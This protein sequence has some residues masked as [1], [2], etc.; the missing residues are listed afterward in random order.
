MKALT[1][2]FIMSLIITLS[3]LIIVFADVDTTPAGAKDIT[4]LG[5]AN[6]GSD[7]TKKLNSLPSGTYYF[8]AGRYG[9]NG[10][11]TA[12][13]MWVGFKPK[14]NS[15][16]IFAEDA[17]IKV[18]T[19]GYPSYAGILLFNVTNVN[20]INPTVEGD[21]LTH[22]F[23][24]DSTHEWGHGIL[25]VGGTGIVNIE[26]P[27]IYDVTGD[28]IDIISESSDV[29]ITDILIERAR[30]Q[31]ISIESAGTVVINGGTIRDISGAAPASGIDIEP[32]EVDQHLDNITISNIT[33][34]NTHQG[35]LFSNLHMASNYNVT[36]NNCT[37]DG[38]A[39]FNIKKTTSGVVNINN[40]II[41]GS[42]L[43][44]VWSN[45]YANINISNPVFNFSKFSGNALSEGIIQ[46]I[47]A[48]RDNGDVLGGL[49]VTNAQ[50]LN[51]QSDNESTALFYFFNTSKTT[52][53]NISIE[54]TRSN[55]T[56]YIW[57]RTPS[58]LSDISLSV[59]DND[60]LVASLK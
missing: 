53:S 59:P 29:T 43:G 25:V 35:L 32:Y 10:F 60:S 47:E 39:V 40:P 21:R 22:D 17:V 18:L 15:T 13:D 8:P 11:D 30:R 41:N 52:L 20:L 3:G 56:N 34:I 42:S 50:V 12:S 26:S 6:D 36:V 37:F 28:G 4:K 33:T 44:L 7:I 31:G 19:N 27:H 55:M 14:S 16:Y 51:H 58:T 24:I 2:L 54:V 49:K 45:A 46:F 23:S 48:D 1:K 38:I 5:I 57:A 9:V